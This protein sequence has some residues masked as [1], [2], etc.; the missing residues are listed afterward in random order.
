MKAIKIL[1]PMLCIALLFSGCGGF[2][3]AS[4]IDDLISPVAPAGA[5]ASVQSAMD[6]YCKGGYSVKIPAAGKYTTS[7]IFYDFDENTLP[8]LFYRKAWDVGIDY[9]IIASEK[10]SF[11]ERYK[12]HLIEMSQ[13]A[14]PLTLKSKFS[15]YRKTLLKKLGLKKSSAV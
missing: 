9:R 4:S 15:A 13:V 10:I 5:D 14:E 12:V 7:Y 11:A 2:H 8:Y 6:A 1:I 3:L